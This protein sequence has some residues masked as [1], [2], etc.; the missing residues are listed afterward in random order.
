MEDTKLYTK[1]SSRTSLNEELTIQ[2]CSDKTYPKNE[3]R[4]MSI[5]ELLERFPKSQAGY[6]FREH[7]YPF[8]RCLRVFFISHYD[9][10]VA[11]MYERDSISGLSKEHIGQIEKLLKKYNKNI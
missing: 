10:D 8:V 6:V 1:K 7:D 11:P 2:F 9:M 3:I 5:E 4:T